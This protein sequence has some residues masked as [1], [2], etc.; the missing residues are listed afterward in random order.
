MLVPIYLGLCRVADLDRGHEAANVLISADLGM[1]VEVSVVHSVA[2][3]AAG[4]LSAWLKCI[5][6]SDLISLCRAE[7]V[8]FQMRLGPLGPPPWSVLAR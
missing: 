6:T 1:A 2:M 8:Q 3:I 5:A 4:G 7:L